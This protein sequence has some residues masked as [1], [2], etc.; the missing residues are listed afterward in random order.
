MNSHNHRSTFKKELRYIKKP[1]V[2]LTLIKTRFNSKFNIFPKIALHN[3][4]TTP[5]MVILI[6]CCASIEA[7]CGY[8][9]KYVH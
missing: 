3:C 6:L 4:L 2:K 7:S 9:I 8:L 5:V 1:Q